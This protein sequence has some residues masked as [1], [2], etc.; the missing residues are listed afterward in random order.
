MKRTALVAA[1]SLF[2]LGVLSLYL[3]TLGLTPVRTSSSLIA[4]SKLRVEQSRH[5]PLARILDFSWRTTWEIRKS[6]DQGTE[7]LY[8]TDKASISDRA[9]IGVLPNGKYFLRITNEA[10]RILA[11]VTFAP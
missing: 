6:S 7:V 8:T 5:T 4:D 9:E 3:W 11:N 1:A 2:L 10:N